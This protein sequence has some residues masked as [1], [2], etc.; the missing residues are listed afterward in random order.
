MGTAAV[1]WLGILAWIVLAMGIGLT[2]ARMIRLRDRQRPG[3]PISTRPG[4]L[5]S[6]RPS[7]K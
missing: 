4:P 7:S 2:L 1:V 6:R 3:S 5:V